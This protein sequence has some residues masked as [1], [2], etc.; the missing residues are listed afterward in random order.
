M[1]R[2]IY[3]ILQHAVMGKQVE[4]LE[5]QAVLSLNLLQ[6]LL[7]R[8]NRFPVRAG[9]GRFLPKIYHLAAVHGFQHGGTAQQGGFTGS[10]GTDD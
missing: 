1:D 7:R 4:I 8:I 9:K 10:G 5:Y 3:D 6:F 2:R